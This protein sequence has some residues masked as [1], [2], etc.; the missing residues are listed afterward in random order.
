MQSSYEAIGQISDD[1]RSIDIH[2]FELYSSPFELLKGVDLHITI[3]KR[4]RKRSVQQNA[5]FHAVI[6][7][8]IKDFLKE[9]SG[10][11][12]DNEQVK[13]FIY[14]EI[15]GMQFRE[16]EIAGK[17]YYELVGKRMSQRTTEQFNEAKEII[18]EKMALLDIVIPDPSPKKYNLL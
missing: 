10:V 17:N 3:K 15:V 16:T 13:L 11:T 7:P 4:G 5:Y 1:K 2:N 12:Y 8:I 14:H 9:T 18:Q 6:V